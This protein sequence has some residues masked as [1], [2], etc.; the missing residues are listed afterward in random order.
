MDE[1]T[2]DAVKILEKRY[3][4]GHPLR[5]IRVKIGVIASRLFAFFY[6]LVEKV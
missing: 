5:Q 6:R 2:S 1:K 4:K 3:L